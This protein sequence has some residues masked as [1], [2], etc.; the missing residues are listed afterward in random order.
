[1]NVSNVSQTVE[2]DLRSMGMRSQVVHDIISEAEYSISA[3]S[4][5]T[6][7]LKPYQTVWLKDDTRRDLKEAATS[8]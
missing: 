1:V 8:I 2:I 4:I 5:L 6:F 3:D 7:K